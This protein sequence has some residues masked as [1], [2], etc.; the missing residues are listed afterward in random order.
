MPQPLIQQADHSAP[1]VLQ[2]PGVDNI[3]ALSVD[4][5]AGVYEG[6]PSSYH[7]VVR[8][9]TGIDHRIVNAGQ[10]AVERSAHLS[11]ELFDDSL[12]DGGCRARGSEVL[13][14]ENGALGI[15]VNEARK[16]LLS[17]H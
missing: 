17:D 14:E 11:L 7:E 5:P 16:M 1:I 8:S 2:I 6:L 4:I 9:S 15:D 12:V 13:S 3:L 10:A